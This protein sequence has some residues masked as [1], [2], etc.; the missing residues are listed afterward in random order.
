MKLE[1]GKI[2]SCASGSWFLC[3]GVR[4]CGVRLD[5]EGGKIDEKR[6]GFTLPKWFKNCSISRCEKT[7]R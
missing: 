4:V 5:K 2:K 1:S 6:Q 7:T 3:E